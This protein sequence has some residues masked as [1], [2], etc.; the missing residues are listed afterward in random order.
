M[1]LNQRLTRNERYSRGQTLQQR[2]GIHKQEKNK[3][4]KII[5]KRMN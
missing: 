5:T 3:E 2:L 4:K 1:D